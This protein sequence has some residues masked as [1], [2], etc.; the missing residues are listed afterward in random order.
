MLWMLALQNHDHF[1][2]D[3]LPGASEFRE[4]DRDPQE[5]RVR[6]SDFLL[7]E[8]LIALHHIS[9]TIKPWEVCR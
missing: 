3:S 1:Y 6:H 2:P 4:P 5:D 8:F 7:W 9:G